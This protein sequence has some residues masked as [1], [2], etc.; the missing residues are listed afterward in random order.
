[1]PDPRHESG[2]RAEEMAA[3][4][5]LAAGCEILLRNFRRRVGE[6]DIVARR[7][8]VLIIAEVRTRASTAYGGAAASVTA[9]KQRRIVRAA[10]ALLQQRPD[11][12]RLPVRFDVIVVSDLHAPHPRIEWIQHAFVTA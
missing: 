11:L 8:G 5:L 2:R 12:A 6:L 3:A 7:D 1:M 9:A 4:H 10:G